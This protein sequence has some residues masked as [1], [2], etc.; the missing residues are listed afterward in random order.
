M[1]QC[2]QKG[3]TSFLKIWNRPFFFGGTVS[4]E[5]PVATVADVFCGSVELSEAPAG[6]SAGDFGSTAFPS[7]RLSSLTG[8]ATMVFAPAS[9]SEVFAVSTSARAP[10]RTGPCRVALGQSGAAPAP[11]TQP[12]PPSRSTSPEPIGKALGR[13]FGR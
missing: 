6:G 9:P 8:L 11:S 4:A 13:I 10:R 7:A 5:S 12:S 1:M 2:D 3:L